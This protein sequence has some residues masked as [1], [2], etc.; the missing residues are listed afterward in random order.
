MNNY[1]KPGPAITI[2]VALNAQIENFPGT[3]S[4]YFAGNVMPGYFDESNQEK[5]RTISYVNRDK[6]SVNWNVF[7]DK[8]YESF[9]RGLHQ[10]RN[11]PERTRGRSYAM[12]NGFHDFAKGRGIV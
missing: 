1:Y 2:K 7:V 12:G 8:P 4:Y 6:S 11:V 3:Q 9:D 5:G 10:S